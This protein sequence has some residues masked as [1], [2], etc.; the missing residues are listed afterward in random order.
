MAHAQRP[1][2][3]ARLT[4]RPS[5]RGPQTAIVLASGGG[6]VGP[7]DDYCCVRIRT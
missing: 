2:R 7:D 5:V 3:P 1:F 6:D 4:P